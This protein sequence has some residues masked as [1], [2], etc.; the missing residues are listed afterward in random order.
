MSAATRVASQPTHAFTGTGTLVQFMFHRD[1]IRMPAWIYG[2]AMMVVDVATALGFLLDDAAQQSFAIL[3]K[4]PVMGL[5]GGPNFGFDDI[6]VPRII[7]SIYG[8]YFMLGAAMMSLMTVSRHMRIEEQTGRAELIRA[9]VIGRH[10][11]LSAALIVTVVMNVGVG[12]VAS[13]LMYFSFARPDSFV[14]CLLFGASITAAGLVFA[15]VAAVTTQLSAYSRAGSGMAGAV[16]GVAFMIRGLGDMSATQNGDL[17]WLAWLSPLGWSQQTAP[18][19]YNRWW[20][21]LLSVAVAALLVGVSFLLLDRRDLGS[22]IFPEKLGSSRA[23]AWLN[24]PFAV[25]F[26]LQRSSILGWSVALVIGGLAMGAFA[27]PMLDAMDGLPPEISLILGSGEN[28]IA[29]YLGFMGLF[30]GMLV[31]VFGI[32]A[33]QMVLGEEQ[34]VRVE[35]IISASVGRAKWLLSWTA[36]TLMGAF[37]LLVLAGTATSLGAELSGAG[38]MF[39]DVVVG[40]VIHGAAVTFLVGIAV[41]L[42]G[43]VPRMTGLAWVVF[44][45]GFFASLFGPAIRLGQTWMDLSVFSHVGQFPGVPVAWDGVAIVAGIGALMVAGGAAG[46]ARRDLITA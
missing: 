15:G 29:G 2:F 41:L 1:R 22:G 44:G 38:G 42:Y 40:H 27:R 37:W 28:M 20:P 30:D 5:I 10:A 39:G 43:F 32:I 8:L 11:Q 25:A 35:P 34:S 19:T 46:F 17:T 13:L 23:A 18:F 4:N 3:A 12:I 6:S 24:S 45:Y 26:R 21:L 33:V 9:N 7:A 36:V 16:L 31:A 14:A